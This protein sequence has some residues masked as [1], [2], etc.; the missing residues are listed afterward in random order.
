MS[1]GDTIQCSGLQDAINRMDALLNE[2]YDVELAFGQGK[3]ELT[4]L[5]V[6]EE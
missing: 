2:G 3:A 1:V 6:P 4:I 5:E